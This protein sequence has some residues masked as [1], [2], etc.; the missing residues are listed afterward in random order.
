MGLREAIDEVNKALEKSAKLTTKQRK[1]LKDSQFCGPGR[2]FPVNDC[3]HYTAALRLLN[4][5]KYSDA[6]KKKIRACVNRK[7]RQLGCTNKKEK[8]ADIEE[9]INSEVFETTRKLVE[10][11]I[12][13]P[14][15]DL[16]FSEVS[17]CLDCG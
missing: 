1:K 7:G 10:E 11:S 12:N 6:T 2:S 3:A 16:D 15:M 14:G 8:S 4:R 9:L 13:N 5:S 17:N